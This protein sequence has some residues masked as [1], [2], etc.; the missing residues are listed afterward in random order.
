[1]RF[2][3]LMA[4]FVSQSCFA[5]TLTKVQN[6]Q[7][8]ELSLGQAIEIRLDENPTTGYR[9]VFK[10]TPQL[11]SDDSFEMKSSKSNQRALVGAGGVRVIKLKPAQK[12]AYD[13]K[14]TY[15]RSWETKAPIQTISYHLIVK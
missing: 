13:I 5:L 10:M 14:A 11:E 6:N 3:F 9:W 1:M 2:L 12:G 8:I 15:Q 4:L 7:T